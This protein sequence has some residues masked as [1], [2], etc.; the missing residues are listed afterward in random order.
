MSSPAEKNHSLKLKNL[1]DEQVEKLLKDFN[2]GLTISE[3]RHIEEKILGRPMTLTEATAWSIEGS[4]HCSYR[5][6]RHHLK[7]LPTDGP[8]VILGPK[9]DA[10]IVEIA[11]HNGERWG[12][13]I[14]HE[15]HNHPSQIVPY[16]GAATGIG[17]NVR[18][19]C[20]MGA[21]VIASADPLRFGQIDSNKSKWVASGVID[22]IAGYGNPI[23]VPI[24]AGD[25]YWNSSFNENCLVNVVA[26]GIVKESE[27][28]HS[29]APKGAGEGSYDY[30]LAGKPT[31]NSGFGGASFASFELDEKE[32][33]KNK[34]AVQE[35]NAFLKRH[36]LE[37]TY[38]LFK[39]L[40]EK[41]LLDRVGFKD[42]GGGGILCATV[43]MADAAGYGAEI[44]LEKIHVAML[45]LPPQVVLAAETQER[46]MWIVHPDI[47][48]LI[49]DHY[50]KKWALPEVS[51]GARASVIGKVT[52]GGQYAVKHQGVKVIEA[53]ACD[54][55]EGLK[56]D[57][58]IKEPNQK[59]Q[60]PRLR[61][62][63]GGQAKNLNQILLKI[64][65]HEN[66]SSRDCIYERYDKTVQGLTIIEPGRAD[67]GVMSPLIA[68]DLP[69]DLKKIG[70]ALSV[71]CNPFYSR[72]SPYWGAV[73]A[74]AEAMRNVAAVGAVPWA[75]TD[76]L[77]YG[78]P[79]KPEQMWQ[80][81]EGVRGVAEACKN[82]HLKGHG[83]AP[84]PVV[85]GNVSLYNE[86][87]KGAVD[88]SAII[89]C[90]GRMSDYH[91]A[92]T[93]EFKEPDSVIMLIG[94]R[95]DELGGSVYYQLHNELGA[96]VPQLDFTEVKNQIYAV[97]DLIDEGLLLSCHDIS[98]GG[99]ATAI[100]EMCF[101][102]DAKNRIGC[103]VEL[104][105]TSDI[106]LHSSIKLFSETGGFVLE[107][108]N[109]DKV[110]QICKKNNVEAI[111]I[112]M[113]NDEGRMNVNNQ[114][115]KIIDIE[116]AEMAEEWL[117]GLR[118]KITN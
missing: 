7:S 75:V 80:F 49:L 26:L 45:N 23:G 90:L 46:F 79:E 68:E 44:W 81:V 24:I 5:S 105:N 114:N 28:I 54:I 71:D 77:N 31:D 11:R 37:S 57:R 84:V 40:K 64:L 59:N 39:T 33:E 67:A 25:V 65:E 41:H 22:G 99:L 55:T 101:G 86:S 98:D 70:I 87:K 58:P 109:P 17:G 21:K 27:I 1:S 82:I 19:I 78:N 51:T 10:G 94:Q 92:I 30:I 38:D 102:G 104:D 14:S 3:A 115:E 56:Y 50:N 12:I 85:S 63:F 53:Q 52:V 4:E 96:N 62:G 61:Q 2:I 8:N 18:D 117:N 107:T 36:L 35:P 93:M 15:S 89:A 42:L 110:R 48:S 66:I 111:K 113:T 60:E 43:E 13:V 16:E 88:P 9:E 108:K 29:K 118:E 112:G 106:D 116:V 103:D 97:T 6:S 76:C 74:V 83:D 72:I 34:G 32:L 69:E 20:C 47:T 95:K 100:A 91:K 73:N